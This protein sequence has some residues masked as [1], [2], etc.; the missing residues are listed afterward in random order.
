MFRSPLH[1]VRTASWLGLAL[2]VTFSVCFVT[3]LL[4]H[5]WQHPPNWLT[6]PPRPV[7]LYRLTQGLH[8]ASGL[9]SVPLLLAKLWAV[10]PRLW[11]WPPVRTLAH[12]LDRLAVFLLVTVSV[13]QLWTGVANAAED[14]RGFGFFFTTTHFW[15]AFAVMG[16]VLLHTAT[17]ASIARDA[18]RRAPPVEPVQPAPPAS[19]DTAAPPRGGGMTRRGFLAATGVTS[20][21]VA[22]TGVAASVPGL[23]DLGV[24]APRDPRVGPQGLPVNKTAAAAGVAAAATSPGYRLEVVG[25]VPQQLSIERLAGLPQHTVGLPIT[26]VEGWSADATWTGVR[27]RDLVELAGGAADAGVRVE[28]LEAAGPYRTSEVGPAHVRDPLTLLA[29]RLNGQPLALDHGYPARLIAA[30]RPGVLQTKWVTRV[31]VL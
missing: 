20:G 17:R 29:L 25:P 14:Y 5:Y 28:S 22:V 1:D 7:W 6:V 10:Y 26:C 24:L 8:V 16:A 9:A 18:L 30:D 31:V 19:Q 15:M 12:G 23:A 3:G 27:L 4:S 21:I 2:A 11:Q 13:F